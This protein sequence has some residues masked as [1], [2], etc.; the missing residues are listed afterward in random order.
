MCTSIVFQ[1]TFK[2]Y[3][4]ASWH[5]KG[6]VSLPGGVKLTG[7]YSY[8]K[9]LY[10]TVNHRCLIKLHTTDLIRMPKRGPGSYCIYYENFPW[11]KSTD[12]VE[13]CLCGVACFTWLARHTSV[14]LVWHTNIDCTNQT[15]TRHSFNADHCNRCP[16]LT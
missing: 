13:Q 2:S 4:L 10:P 3:I 7:N 9:P 12:F 16:V 11:M 15:I 5:P 6:T 1:N 8:P 14:L